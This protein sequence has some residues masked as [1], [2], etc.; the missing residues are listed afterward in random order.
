MTAGQFG[1]PADLLIELRRRGVELW[2]DQELLRFRAPVGAIDET[3]RAAM[4]AWRGDLIGLLSA[5]ADP[6]PLT[7][8]QL[9]LW[10]LELRQGATPE[11][12]MNAAFRLRGTLDLE[13]LQQAVQAVLRRHPVLECVV[14]TA[15]DG[16]PVL[17]E[18]PG[19]AEMTVIDLG[20]ATDALIGQVAAD[21]VVR[22]IRLAEGPL[23]RIGILR[24]RDDDHVVVLV[25]HHLISDDFSI[26]LVCTEMLD[27]YQ[28]LRESGRHPA[29]WATRTAAGRPVDCDDATEHRTE[30]IVRRRDELAAAGRPKLPEPEQPGDPMP[31]ESGTAFAVADSA[32]RATW[33]QRRRAARATTSVMTLALTAIAVAAAGG[34]AHLL[35]GTPFHGRDSTGDQ[36]AVG[37]FARPL[38]IQTRMHPTTTFGELI[39]AITHDVRSALTVSD[40]SY[41]LLAD[42]IHSAA[43]G[44]VLWVVTYGA[45][46]LPQLSGLAVEPLPIGVDTARHDLRVALADHTT[47]LE[48]S[49]THRRRTVDAVFAGRVTAALGLLLRRVPA[50]AETV[51]AI[52][53]RTGAISAGGVA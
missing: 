2:L 13:V 37:Y 52:W 4:S 14:A 40:I 1:T 16:L 28:A 25:I 15:A 33:E 35:I 3:I 34:P 47:H 19:S 6:R 27:C 9:R 29:G 32:E 17:V 5:P 45:E 53:H 18:R 41:E 38:I 8:R 11:Y 31:W 48:L 49:V 43:G 44:H 42:D 21:F 23:S 10:L 36:H 30:L 50:R 26:R 20:G 39:D 51:A 7:D 24:A 22:P 12:H 46:S